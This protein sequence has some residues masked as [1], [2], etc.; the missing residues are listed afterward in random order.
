M[1]FP[2]SPDNHQSKQC[3]MQLILLPN[4]PL[5]RVIKVFASGSMRCRLDYDT[6][7]GDQ[8]YSS[9]KNTMKMLKPLLQKICVGLDLSFPVEKNIQSLLA[10][11][12]DDTV[13]TVQASPMTEDMQVDKLFQ[14]DFTPTR[15]LR[16]FC[17]DMGVAALARRDWK[18]GTI[19]AEVPLCVATANIQNDPLLDTD[20]LAIIL[21]P[22]Y[23]EVDSVKRVLDLC[24]EKGVPCLIIN[25]DLINMDQGFGVRKCCKSRKYMPVSNGFVNA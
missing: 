6:S 18:M 5:I 10:G 14:V 23:S 22:L 15:T 20:R 2:L 17:P 24:A 1:R 3:G 8:T 7:V 13:T 25:P 9:V 19:M 16:V 12:S 4:K 21:C 11:N